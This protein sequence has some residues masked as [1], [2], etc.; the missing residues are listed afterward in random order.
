M[1]KSNVN[2]KRM[3]TIQI[4]K[5]LLTLFFCILITFCLTKTLIFIIEKYCLPTKEGT[6]ERQ[7]IL[8]HYYKNENE[9]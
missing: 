6:E 7:P 1:Y 5:I 9:L 8:I 3:D 2:K 4:L